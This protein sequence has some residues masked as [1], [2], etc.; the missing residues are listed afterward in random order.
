MHIPVHWRTLWKC[1]FWLSESGLELRFCISHKLP[2]D[3]RDNDLWTT[4]WGSRAY[5]SSSLT[6]VLICLRWGR[7][8]LVLYLKSGDRKQSLLSYCSV[9]F[10]KETPLFDLFHF[11]P[12]VGC[13][14]QIAHVGRNSFTVIY[15]LCNWG[16]A[17]HLRLQGPAVYFVLD[18]WG[19]SQIWKGEKAIKATY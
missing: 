19:F 13:R 8:A 5:M 9:T 6:G 12:L 16:L 10:S 17:C 15:M 3:V 18:T 1:R 2:D 11:H 4:V 7:S 14:G